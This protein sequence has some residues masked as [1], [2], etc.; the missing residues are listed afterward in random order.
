MLKCIVVDDEQMNRKLIEAYISQVSFLEHVASCKN[1]FEAIKILENNAID[2]MFLDIQMPG[3][4]GTDFLKVLKKKPMTVFVTAYSQYALEGYELEV[5]DYL[6]KPLSIERFTKTAFRALELHQDKEIENIFVN[7][8]YGLVKVKLADVIYVEGLKDYIKIYTEDSPRAIIT[9][10][11]LKAMEE[12]LSPNKFMR[13][14]RSFIVNLAKI[15]KIKGIKLFIGEA[16]I[17]VSENLL[18]AL[19]QKVQSS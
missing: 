1:A 5:I 2:L 8:D 9:K 12:K 14:H 3:M 13:V 15:E 6:M 7:V 11:S 17:P 18:E 19:I 10:M 4:L 16:E